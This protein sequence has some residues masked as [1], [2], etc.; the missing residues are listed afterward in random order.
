MATGVLQSTARKGEGI[1]A[2]LPRFQTDCIDVF[3]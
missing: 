2:S 3:Y 1:Q